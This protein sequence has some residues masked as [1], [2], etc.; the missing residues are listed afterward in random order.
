MSEPPVSRLQDADMQGTYA[1]FLRAAQRAREIAQQT[2]TAVVVMRDGKLVEESQTSSEPTPPASAAKCEDIRRIPS[3]GGDAM[4]S[5]SKSEILKLSVP[6]RILLVEDIWDSIAEVPEEV[7]LSQA[8]ERE[9]DVRL[10]A[11]HRNPAEGSPWA[12]VR[13][14]IRAAHES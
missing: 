10:D 6:E 3:T 7:A 11:Y 2:G 14:R 9:L 8:Q 4:S 1:A 13:D 12:E 5:I